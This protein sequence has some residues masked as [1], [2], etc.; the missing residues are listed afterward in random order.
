MSSSGSSC[1]AASLQQKGQSSKLVS[2]FESASRG[3]ER[4]EGH[5]GRLCSRPALV[6]EPPFLDVGEHSLRI[7]RRR[8]DFLME[9]VQRVKLPE[10]N[11]RRLVK[12]NFVNFA[13]APLNFGEFAMVDRFLQQAIQDVTLIR[14]YVLAVG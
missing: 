14:E 13:R 10:R 2:F 5:P 9:R 6:S 11:H 12:Q 7:E 1:N 3:R 8:F 4:P